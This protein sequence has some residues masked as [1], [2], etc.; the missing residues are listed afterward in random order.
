MWIFLKGT[1][2]TA[3]IL[4]W[5][6]VFGALIA[7]VVA[8]RPEFVAD[9]RIHGGLLFAWCCITGGILNVLSVQD[10]RKPYR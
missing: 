4:C 1:L 8:F 5:L 9:R 3:L 2:K 7:D 10:D 6:G